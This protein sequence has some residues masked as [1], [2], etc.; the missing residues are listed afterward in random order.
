LRNREAARYATWAGMTAGVVVLV[1]AGFYLQRGIRDARV[2]RAQP[3]AVSSGVQQ[4]SAQF[5]FSK[6][7][8]DRTLFTVRASRATQFK[9][10]NRAL[11]E[12]VWITVYGPKGD[13]NDNIHTR[14]CSYSPDS[15]DVRCE[16]PVQIDVAPAAV[17]G[18][19]PDKNSAAATLQVTTS[20][21]SFNRNT[22]EASTPA[23]VQ[24]HF[25][26]GHGSGVGV[27]YSQSDSVVRVQH[28]IEFDLEASPHTGGMPATATGSALD[29]RRDQHDLVLEGPAVV[30]QGTRDLAADRISV[31]LD[32][33]NHARTVIAEGHPQIH[34]QE[35][36]AKVTV[37]AQ[38]IET[39]LNPAGWAEK[40]VADGPVNATRESSSGTDKFS[41]AKVEI[42]MLAGRNLA[43]ELTA[44]GNVVAES[45]QGGDSR[46]LKTDALRVTFSSA[47]VKGAAAAGNASAKLTGGQRVESAE[48][49]APATIVTTS[50]T[51]TTTL[52]AK[53]FVAG[54]GPSGRLE[55]LFGHG[56]V[57]VRREL[58]KQALQ[59]IT[60]AEMVATFAPSGEWDT[61]DESGGVH[62]QQADRQVTA[63]H[64]NFVRATNVVMLDGSPM[65]SDS[66]SRTTAANVV[67]DQQSGQVRATGGVV[68][69]Y[70][71]TG[72]GDTVGLG[73]GSAHVSADALSGSINSGQAA[74]TGHARLWQGDSVLD[75]DRIELWRDDKR[76]LATGHV[77]AVF[78]QA[79]GPL[80]QSFSQVGGSGP[81][82]S[83]KTTSPAKTPVTTSSA[84][85]SIPGA[86]S[87]NG[88]ALWKVVAPSL[89]YWSDQGKARLEGGVLASSS[90]ASLASR[91]MDVYLGP[92]M[93]S[94]TP[95]PGA[96]PARSGADP[97]GGG[98]GARQLSRLLAQ[99]SAVVRQGGRRGT[100]EQAEYTA[101]DGKFV[102]S[103]GKPTVTDAASN[104]ASGR[105]LTFF[106]ANDTIL[107]DSQEGSRTLTKH[108]VE[109]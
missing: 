36:G 33:D 104:T 99:G 44:T 61:V 60:A 28:D 89:A 35:G 37:V 67:I 91:T 81:P 52:S 83:G 42:A 49:L 73:A 25:A 62:F 63:A 108:Q 50:A 66:Q 26:G 85:P 92:V 14:E 77:V 71:S 8:Q 21:L 12:D 23:P 54:L 76:L 98:L 27:S 39:A 24:F 106:V 78:S 6:V 30:R 103:G 82:K 65:L 86:D 47:D 3:A 100:A 88:P 18:T 22:G 53:K 87:S 17:P 72:Q 79:G 70:L 43:K 4:Q 11:L 68:S 34:A 109:K 5:S 102:L 45:K 29:I 97:A 80:A 40:I 41:S 46:V 94:A 32:A 51:D 1:V 56:G 10:Q 20:N 59:T 105:S 75:A 7:E 69:T 96:S 9:E 15:G 58:A 57:D 64:A 19:S 84:K 2:R 95:S 48:T 107:L 90:D 31:E 74:Y 55:K 13:R 101:A 38:R 16:G 93:G